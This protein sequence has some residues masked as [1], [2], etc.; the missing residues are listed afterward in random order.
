MKVMDSIAKENMEWRE[1]CVKVR[2]GS[3]VIF[4]NSTELD[5]GESVELNLQ[6]PEY[7]R[8][9][10]ELTKEQ[11]FEK[12]TPLTLTEEKLSDLS[13]M[14][15]IY[16][17]YDEDDQKYVWEVDSDSDYI[18]GVT[19]YTLRDARQFANLLNDN[20]INII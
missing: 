5:K 9:G 10:V 11:I 3:R 19:Y 8:K 7:I 17:Y 20:N 2:V 18:L 14:W 15:Y 16:S 6:C 4:D 13:D 1:L 12:F